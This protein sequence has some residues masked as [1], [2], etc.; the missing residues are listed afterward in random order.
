MIITLNFQVFNSP[1]YIFVFETM[2]F[3]RIF[4]NYLSSDDICKL[5]AL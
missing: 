5:I 1:V 3:K 4:V 2:A